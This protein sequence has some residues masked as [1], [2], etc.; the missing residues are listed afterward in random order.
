MKKQQKRRWRYKPKLWVIL[1]MTAIVMI[2]LVVGGTIFFYRVLLENRYVATLSRQLYDS[3]ELLERHC[4]AEEDV[5]EVQSRGI[6]LLILREPDD[7]ILYRSTAGRTMFRVNDEDGS[8]LNEPPQSVQQEV[9]YFR[10]LIDANLGLAPGKTVVLDPHDTA[11]SRPLDSR[12]MFLL[13]RKGDTIYCL[14]LPV[15]STN[16]AINLA[17]RYSTIAAL[18]GILAGVFLVYLVSRSVTHP[19]R[20]IVRTAGKIAELDFS[21]RCQPVPVRELD[22]L[23]TSIN[24]MADRLQAAISELQSTN[25]QLQREL[26]DRTRQQKEHTE[27]LANLSHDLKTPIAIISGYAEGLQEGI[28][29]TPEQR[30]KYYSI[31]MKESEDM[32]RIVSRMLASTRLDSGSIPLVIEDFDLAALLDEMFAL[33]QRDIERA[34]LEVELDYPR[35]LMA[36]TDYESIR[37][38]VLNYAQNAVHH[39]NH[40]NKIR[41]SVERKDKLLR[42]SVINSSA[43]ISREE[44][45]RIWEKLYRG[46]HARQRSHGEAGLGLA[47]VR[48]NMERLGLDYGCRNLEGNRVEFWLCIPAGEETI[49]N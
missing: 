48:G 44:Q 23:S 46:D 11:H 34:G 24:T 4:F 35:P 47:I 28:A 15:E 10:R 40:G 22:E 20:D 45:S 13:G 39:I 27:L 19:H 17:V 2:V 36:R 25:E 43:P 31:L 21:A 3:A 41:V 49:E 37:Q 26:D 14:Y 29:H 8:T 16:A 33:F 12:D 5:A 32:S 9:R 6:W 30:E 1:A 38:S 42:L 18:I 7:Q